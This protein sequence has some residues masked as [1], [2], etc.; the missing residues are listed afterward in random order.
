MSNYTEDSNKNNSIILDHDGQK[1]LLET[2]KWAKFLSILGFIGIG[3]MVVGGLL[4][5]TFMGSMGK[6]MESTPSNGAMALSGTVMA[7]IY[8]LIAAVYFFPILYLY[9]FSTRTKEALV[10]G[11]SQGLSI[12]IENLKKHYKFVG[13]LAVI[14]LSLYAL[15][16]IFTILF[17]GFAAMN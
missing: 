12:G 1:F 7:V 17:G 3:F 15:I 10:S 16:F 11:N 6:M 8:V 2:C 13:I 14:I 5:G 4:F 9:R